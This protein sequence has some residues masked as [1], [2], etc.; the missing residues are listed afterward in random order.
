MS[1]N[2]M[3]SQTTHAHIRPVFHP[4][5][6]AMIDGRSA[7]RYLRFLRPVRLERLELPYSVYGRWTPDVPVHPAH[8]IVSTFDDQKMDWRQVASVDVEPVP[9]IWGEGLT[10]R[11]SIA[12]MEAHFKQ[13]LADVPPIQIPLDGL[14]THMLRVECDREHPVWPNH[15]ENYANRF[16]VPFGTLNPLRAF[17][18]PLAPLP[19]PE[20]IPV[21]RTGRIAPSGGAGLSWR[22]W[23]ETIIFE[24]PYLSAGFSLRRPI[25]M[26]LGWDALGEGQASRSRISTRRVS[27]ND[28]NRGVSG[29]MYLTPAGDYGSHRWTGQVE[30]LGNQ[31]I[32]SG[33]TGPAG[34]SVDATFTVEA[35]R[36]MV[37][38]TQRAEYEVPVLEGEVWRL[39]WDL[40]RGMTAAAGAPTLVPG[41]SGDLH[42]PAVFASDGVGC[43]RCTVL[44]GS[45]GRVGMQVESYRP[46]HEVAA[47]WV[48]GQRPE[49]SGCRVIQPGVERAV[50]ELAVDN[51]Q[52]V[53]VGNSANSEDKSQPGVGVRRH[54]ASSFSCYRPEWGGFSNHAASVNCHVNQHGQVEVAAFTQKTIPGYN[55]LDAARFTIT[56]ALMDGSGY[57]YWRN[58][59]LD[60]DP[61]L[62]SSAGRIFQVEPDLGWL[63]SVAPGLI[64]ATQRILSTIGEQGLSI[65]RDLTGNSGSHRWSSNAWDIVGFGYMDAYVNAWSYRALRSAAVLARALGQNDLAAQAE[66]GA[67]SLKANYARY[68]INP[69]TGWVMGW[70]SQDGQIHDYGYLWINGPACAFGVLE[71]DTAR[72]ALQNLEA[73][74][75]SLG[76]ESARLGLP[77]NLLPLK[78]EDHMMASVMKYYWTEPTFET[79]TDGSVSPSA[80]T[81]YLRALSIHGF[82]DSARAMAADL[83]AGFADGLFTGGAGM[84]FGRGNE[85]LS[86]EGLASG[87]E[88]TFG[89]T[90]GALYGVAIEQGLFSPPDPEWWPAG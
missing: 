81:Y 74:R 48:L 55:P 40:A 69:E 38:L 50:I 32:Y 79:F 73:R 15:G 87:Y 9:R 43:L 30:V 82:S 67:A 4:E 86:W 78:P 46:S 31:V 36:L 90:M 39:V 72:Q 70:R 20:V 16:Q 58:L 59:Y 25:L 80:I 24:S 57:G 27:F 52:P 5:L 14:E 65:C 42:L 22:R 6:A 12:E 56:R 71:P 75:R 51:L 17:G 83:D 37:E 77:F 26:H 85:F 11:N 68:L 3:Y 21:L 64:Q 28:A 33:L 53:G 41:R 7:V 49:A 2:L 60:S 88:G 44:E 63:R 89:P 45:T 10:Q 23:G 35:D 18:A 62:I 47:G 29:P 1:E 61:V 76:M 34:L 54:W 66:D 8:I 19:Q 84:S 13:V